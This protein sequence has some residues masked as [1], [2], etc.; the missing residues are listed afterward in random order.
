MVPHVASTGQASLGLRQTGPWGSPW[1]KVTWHGPG[2]FPLSQILS[3]V[4]KLTSQLAC[5]CDSTCNGLVS[6]YTNLSCLLCRKMWS[7][8]L[9]TWG[10]CTETLTIHEVKF[11]VIIYN[12]GHCEKWL[13]LCK[14]LIF[15]SASLKIWTDFPSTGFITTGHFHLR[16]Q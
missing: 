14:V 13:S 12:L 7:R 11:L 5:P 16:E 10:T 15:C 6:K 2:P 1:I 9:K 3:V 4:G 8:N